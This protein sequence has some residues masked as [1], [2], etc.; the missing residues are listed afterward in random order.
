MY[1]DP[2]GHLSAYLERI[3]WLLDDH[4]DIAPLL[5]LDRRIAEREDATPLLLPLRHLR[6]TVGL[7]G[8]H[9]ALA[10]ALPMLDV[11][12]GARWYARIHRGLATIDEVVSLLAFHPGDEG[13]VRG[14]IEPLVT[15]GIVQQTSHGTLDVDARVVAFLRGEDG[16]EARLRGLATLHRTVPPAIVTDGIAVLSH[17]LTTPGPIVVEG[18]AGVGKTASL[19]AAIASHGLR[20]V[21]LDLDLVA[22]RPDATDVF[23]LA[24]REALLHKAELVVRARTWSE[25]WPALLR[26]QLVAAVQDREALCTVR[27]GDPLC[28]ELRGPRR[29][30]IAMPTA[31]QQAD[32]WLQQLGDR[33]EAAELD[34]S[35]VVTRYPLAIGDILQAGAAARAVAELATRAITSD[36]L[37]A[38]ARARIA[39]RLGDI[40]DLVSTTLTWEDLVLRPDVDAR[41]RE[42]VGAFRHR[43]HVMQD[44]GFA[45]KLPYGRSLS[46]MFSGAPGTGKTMVAT[47]IGKELGLE[48]FRVDLSKIVSKFIG[49]T[50]KNLDRVFTEASRCRAMLLFDEADSLFA[51]RTEVKSSNDRY[52]NLE[53]NFLLQRIETHDGVV[54]LTTNAATSIDPAFLRRLRYR[55]EFPRPD[56]SERALLWRSM[57]PKAAPIAGDVDFGLLGERFKMSGGN[58]KN[59]VVRAAYLAAS[60][61]LTALD[62]ATLVTAAR[63]EW[64]ELGNLPD[65]I[66]QPLATEPE[67][68][69]TVDA[70]LLDVLARQPGPG[71]TIEVCFCRKEREVGALLA[72]LP[73]SD[74]R[75]MH[76][77]LSRDP[78]PG[79]ELAVQFS[80][81]K[82]DRR[83]RLLD[84]LANARRR[85]AIT[86]TKRAS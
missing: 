6:D 49:E 85:A 72:E 5:E 51:K 22:S 34:V 21:E 11:E 48:V 26:N 78:S 28:R 38:A 63:L 54:I 7:A 20:V 24:R 58:I 32:V 15:L 35:I 77:R 52:A 61:G 3:A 60:S 65:A 1:P 16:F 64:S 69:E 71:E 45:Q 9:V 31:E 46:A 75:A 29:V 66:L 56:A 47:L 84:F 25:A 12:L 4:D 42:I 27:D 36:D 17:V 68:R 59:S 83:R 73:V 57:I 37:L 13:A 86:H 80:R 76:R 8:V 81:L 33:A 40:A 19:V 44:W 14:A 18:P 2:A 39:H 53:V 70:C 23:A 10:V 67:A 43:D 62:H 30:R 74:A 55:V 82:L 79:D 41:L 50:E